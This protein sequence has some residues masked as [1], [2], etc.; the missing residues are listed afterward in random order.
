MNLGK[1]IIRL[2]LR[3]LL[4]GNL[5]K[6]TLFAQKEKNQKTLSSQLKPIVEAYRLIKTTVKIN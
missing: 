1:L 2:F 3:H 5:K 4:H 6:D